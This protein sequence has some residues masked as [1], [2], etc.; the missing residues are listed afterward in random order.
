MVSHEFVDV[1]LANALG[2]ANFDGRQTLLDVSPQSV[3]SFETHV[4]HCFLVA[5]IFSHIVHFLSPIS[6]IILFSRFGNVNNFIP[7]W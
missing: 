1:G 2:I 4:I 6:V 5:K 7:K 3:L